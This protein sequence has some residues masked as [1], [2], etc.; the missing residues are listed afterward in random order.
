[1]HDHCGDCMK[2]RLVGIVVS[3]SVSMMRRVEV[4]RVL[5]HRA[6]HKT[7]RRKI[8]CHV[9]DAANLSQLGDSVEIIESRPL[10]RLKRWVFVQVV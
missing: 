1:M 6:Y 3:D 5:R 9:H 10:S 8:I 2:K 7:I 4:Q